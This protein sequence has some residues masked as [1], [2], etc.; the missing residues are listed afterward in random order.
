MHT[1]KTIIYVGGFELPDKNAA[2]QRVLANAKIFRDLGYNVVLVGID[3]SLSQDTLIKNTQV[4]V[5]GFESWA[6]PYPNDKK[7]GLSLLHPINISSIL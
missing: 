1:K 2:A 4:S 5:S 7:N 6:L 3:K